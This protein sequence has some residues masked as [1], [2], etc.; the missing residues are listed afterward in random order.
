MQL[1]NKT[2]I[3]IIM[4]TLALSACD[5]KNDLTQTKTKV[6]YPAKIDTSFNVK[7]GDTVFYKI[8][9]DEINNM[10]DP[11][12]KRNYDKIN[13]LSSNKYNTTILKTPSDSK[14]SLTLTVK[15]IIDDTILLEAKFNRITKNFY[16]LYSKINTDTARKG[17]AEGNISEIFNIRAYDDSPSNRPDI[18]Y[19]ALVLQTF[20][21]QLSK[22]GGFIRLKDYPTISE[23]IPN[24]SNLEAKDYEDLINKYKALLWIY[25]EQSISHLFT[26]LFPAR[27]VQPV[28]VNDTWQSHYAMDFFDNKFLPN[29]SIYQVDKGKIFYKTAYSRQEDPMDQFSLEYMGQVKLWPIEG[30]YIFD[31]KSQKEDEIITGLKRITQTDIYRTIN[32]VIDE[33]GN[34]LESEED[35][36]ITAKHNY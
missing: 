22:D 33:T 1:I 14:A 5:N 4:L 13:T 21:V 27:T 7:V 11:I 25:N 3:L 32:I 9:I 28:T 31:R 19:K 29:F 6:D 18:L 26:L 15:E 35:F 2:I 34:S 20:Y 8:A 10:Y 23:L 36:D 12:T 17:N 16:G 24:S 30:K